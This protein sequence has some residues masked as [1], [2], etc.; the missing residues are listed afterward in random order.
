MGHLLPLQDRK[1]IPLDEHLH[2]VGV[3]WFLI[4][5]LDVEKGRGVEEVG[6]TDGGLNDLFHRLDHLHQ[7][8]EV[9]NVVPV[10]GEHLGEFLVEVDIVEVANIDDLGDEAQ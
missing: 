9:F 2:L 4:L 5:S 7:E 8:M 3:G 6:H 1:P 10:V